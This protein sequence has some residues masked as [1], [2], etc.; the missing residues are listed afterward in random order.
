MFFVKKG[1]FFCLLQ[2][3]G[4]FFESDVTFRD[5]QRHFEIIFAD[6]P[7]LKGDVTS[8]QP[9]KFLAKLAYFPH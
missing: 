5:P 3:K 7:F 9:L 4:T 8:G 1:T 2:K 6:P